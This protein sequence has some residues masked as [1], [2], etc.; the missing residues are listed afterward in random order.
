MAFLG[1]FPL[2]LSNS[3]RQL[4]NMSKTTLLMIIGYCCREVVLNLVFYVQDKIFS[5]ILMVMHELH[6]LINLRQ[7]TYT[8]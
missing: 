6:F 3:K 1:Y 7:K 5:L 2:D 4:I 8:L